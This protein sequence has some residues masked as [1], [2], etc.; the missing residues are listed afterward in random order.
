MIAGYDG[1]MSKA[2]LVVWGRGSSMISAIEDK[3]IG[4]EY[5]RSWLITL[6]WTAEVASALVCDSSVVGYKKV[7]S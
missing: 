2:T 1:D 7:V 6:P 3:R 4:I 5:G